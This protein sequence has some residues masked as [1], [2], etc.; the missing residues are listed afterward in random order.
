M[1]KEELSVSALKTVFGKL[2]KIKPFI[3]DGDKMPSWDGDIFIYSKSNYSKDNLRKIPS[4]VKGVEVDDL[5]KISISY[6][7]EIKDLINYLE[8]GGVIYFVVAID[9]LSG[10]TNIYYRELLPVFINEQLARHKENIQTIN[11]EF[12]TFPN[13]ESDIMNVCHDFINNRKKQFSFVDEKLPTF[14]DFKGNEDVILTC[15][16]SDYNGTLLNKPEKLLNKDAYF[17]VNAKDQKI[18][19]PISSYATIKS[20]A[21]QLNIPISVAGKQYYDNYHII[22][23]NET[24]IV[25]IGK[26]FSVVFPVKDSD[27]LESPKLNIT[28]KGTLQERIKDLEFV[29]DMSHNESFQVGQLLVPFKLNTDDKKL[30]EEF[31]VLERLEFYKKCQKALDML[32][33]KKPLMLDNITDSDLAKLDCLATSIVDN[34]FVKNIF[35]HLSSQSSMQIAN[36]SITLLCFLNPDKEDECIFKNAYDKDINFYIYDEGN[37]DNQAPAICTLN[38]SNFLKDDNIDYDFILQ[39]IKDTQITPFLIM[40]ANRIM[41]EMLMAYDENHSEELY[42]CIEKLSQF[43]CENDKEDPNIATLNAYQIKKRK[44]TLSA[45]ELQNIENI[46]TTTDK[47]YIKIACY[48]LLDSISLAKI[49]IEKLPDEERQ[50]FTKYPICNLLNKKE[51]NNG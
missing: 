17:Y 8:D 4:Q 48:I 22:I 15:S 3:N 28:T 50:E 14:D 25:Q 5:S 37:K 38:K 26:A 51:I 7:V 10:Y 34:K 46:L 21:R 11:I 20:V 43:L 41:L 44:Q 35:T 16:M 29:N 9:K 23:N 45:E 47:N 24:S 12:R 30:L 6:P 2:D 31:N 32:N 1:D 39:R 18:K 36:I 19:T 33:I 49:M 40:Y 27:K 42:S 13:E